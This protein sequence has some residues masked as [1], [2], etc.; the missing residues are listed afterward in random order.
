VPEGALDVIPHQFGGA[1]AVAGLEGCE[2]RAVLVD[3]VVM[4]LL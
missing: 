3:V 4:P 1:L 2:D